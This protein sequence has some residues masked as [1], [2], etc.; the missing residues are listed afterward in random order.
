MGSAQRKM[1]RDRIRGEK[2]AELQVDPAAET[3]KKPS[4]EVHLFGPLS[5][6]HEES[7]TTHL[8]LSD[9]EQSAIAQRQ[10]KLRQLKAEFD[11]AHA[12]IEGIE[13]GT[14]ARW[15]R[16]WDAALE[17]LGVDE[18]TRKRV[19]GCEVM[20][21]P[22]NRGMSLLRVE[23]KAPQAPA[24]A[25]APPVQPCEGCAETTTKAQEATTS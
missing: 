5:R 23:L 6:S 11:K 25:P 12:E 3:Q 20:A 18:A 8:R 24:P 14:A 2:R 17:D 10:A 22:E 16:I 15:R 9:V 1:H 21:D 19:I 7:A 13:S 4:P